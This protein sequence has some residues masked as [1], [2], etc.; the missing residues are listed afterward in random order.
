M[1]KGII[2]RNEI[3]SAKNLAPE[4]ILLDDVCA[5]IVNENQR[6]IYLWSG[7]DANTSDKFKA[8]RIAH[9]L[10]WKWFGGAAEVIQDNSK[11]KD[12]LSKHARI[13]EEIPPAEIKLILG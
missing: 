10:N 2:L 5:V 6:K 12:I 13:D 11:I 7:K 3:R 9:L 8:A 4:E 1:L